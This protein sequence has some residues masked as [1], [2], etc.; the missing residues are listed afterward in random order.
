[1]SLQGVNDRLMITLNG[2]GT[3]HFDPRPAV[4]AFLWSKERR[5]KEP[6]PE[7]YEQRAF[8]KKFYIEEEVST[9]LHFMM[10]IV[11][12]ASVNSTAN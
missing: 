8:M 6:N 10:F 11:H 4:A 9:C 7:K 3:S 1:M 2:P 5:Y 12:R